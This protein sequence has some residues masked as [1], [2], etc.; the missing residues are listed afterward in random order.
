MAIVGRFIGVD[1]YQ[2]VSIRD[3]TGAKNDALALWSLFVDTI[4][5]IEAEVITGKDATVRKIKN[6]L[7]DSLLKASNNDTVII[8]YSGHGSPDHRI[9]A[10]DTDLTNLTSTSIPMEDIAELFKKSS[11]K[12]ILFVLDCCFSGGAPAKV[13]ES[14]PIP[15]SL[16]N[17]LVSLGGQGRVIIA[18]SNFDEPSYEL[19]S[20]GHGILTKA[21]IDV[22]LSWDSESVNLII[23]MDKIMATVRAE[24]SR[25]GVEQTPVLLNHVTGGLT[26]P[27]LIPGE[28]YF[29]IFPQKR[30]VKI[31]KDI[32]ELTKFGLPI[33]LI[34][35]WSDSYIKGLNE[36]QLEAV[37]E[38]RILDGDSVLVIAPTSS[39]KTFIGELA[40]A[41]NISIG[42][43]AVFLFPY[44]ALV[45][46]K[47]D[48]FTELYQ[49]KLGFRIIRCTG[50]YLDQNNEFIKGKYDIALF[51]YEM[52]L[53]LSVSLPT[54]LD[55]IGLVV[56][57]EAQFITDPTRGISVELLLTNLITAKSRGI[58]P[59]LVVLSAVI[60]DS[61]YFEEWLGCK[62]LLT[63]KRPVPL[64]EGVMGRSGR[65]KYLTEDGEIKTDQLVPS[66]EIVIRRSKASQQDM[67]VPLVKKLVSKKEKVIVFRNQKGPAEGCA[68]YLA[69][70][71]GL[72]P[73]H[74]EIKMLPKYSSS[75]TSP[76]LKKCFEG[77]TAF[78]NSNLS[79][80]ERRIVEKV[81]RDPNSKIRVLAATTTV[82]AGINTPASTVILAEQEFIGEDGRAFTI[83]EY[84][85][86][87]GRAGRVGFNEKGTAIILANAEHNPDLLF[88]KYV[89]G[90][91]ESLSSSFDPE[92]LD[93]WIL[94][95]LAQVKDVH[96]NDLFNL[97]A[98]TYGGYIANRKN[99]EWEKKMREDIVELFANMLRLEIVEDEDGIVHLTIL[100]KICAESVL[101]FRSAMRL[102]ELL[103]FV[104]NPPTPLELMAIVQALPESDIIYTPMFKKGMSEAKWPHEASLRFDN[105]IVILLQKFVNGDAFLYY[106]RSKKASILFDWINGVATSQIEDRFKSNNPFYGNISYSNIRNFA[107]YTR[108]L[109][110]SV[111]KI[112]AIVF[113]AQVPDDVMFDNLLKSLEA[114]I[115]S[116]SLG[117]L[118]LEI[119]ASREEYLA[120]SNNGIKNK[121][122]LLIA[123]LDILERLLES[124]TVEKIK[125]YKNE[126]LQT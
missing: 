66:N 94:K 8:F 82:A 18:A 46:E 28:K 36:V 111:Y 92:A 50:D 2:D 40:S 4:Q 5:K 74:E 100:G 53:N 102:V 68:G 33:N 48:Q 86:M 26:I 54:V 57:D 58:I 87:A 84:K 78:H 29:E 14:S 88:N 105:S 115:P 106:A 109:L 23:A 51:T 10:Y 96:K 63:T 98:N 107:D 112:S 6:A 122:A 59:Q 65:F 24:A 17:P 120:L 124:S 56:L 55:Q 103:K 95:L 73:A 42:K 20:T 38:F 31:G 44:K 108:F 117:L 47:Y 61:N 81:F 91:P 80:E 116:D 72:P 93:T 70:D 76:K 104:Q 110:R 16:G 32:S 13:L 83:A 49:T 126:T 41:K 37:N 39:G 22:F 1:R 25:I 3:L 90:V 67:I 97:L 11:A 75:S 9:T 64:I 35:L 101:S 60:G 43:K 85:N 118:T 45:N 121:E 21:I 19:P 119:E 27:K 79:R 113:P 62:K 123:P 7:E 52:F 30:G 99:P 71:V 114:G 89:L 34:N 77:G 15:R 69:S 12:S 125:Y